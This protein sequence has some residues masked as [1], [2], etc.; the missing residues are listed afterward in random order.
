MTTFQIKYGSKD[1]LSTATPVK[2]CWYVTIDSYELYFCADGQTIKKVNDLTPFDPTPIYDR[3][4]SVESDIANL[5]QYAHESVVTVEQVTDLP[6][7]GRDDIVYI[8]K[9]EN[10]IYR[11]TNNYGSSPYICVGRDY[12]EIDYI[13]C[14]D[15]SY[16]E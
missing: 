6:S 3:L 14:G 1:N 11:W 8:V 10:A 5:Q 13:D 15:A 16:I 7:V 2:G 4:N 9:S 12:N